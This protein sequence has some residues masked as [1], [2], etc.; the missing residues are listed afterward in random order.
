MYQLMK[1]SP[2]DVIPVLSAS[3]GSGSFFVLTVL[4]LGLS[5]L[6]VYLGGRDL[7]Q[8]LP[9]FSPTVRYV[10]YSDK[11][12]QDKCVHSGEKTSKANM[13]ATQFHIL[14]HLSQTPNEVK[15][16]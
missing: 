4:L 16:T 6:S 15:I 9:N 2:D 14:F 10:K 5:V 1:R 12:L 3:V 7:R 11:I 8:Q 13:S